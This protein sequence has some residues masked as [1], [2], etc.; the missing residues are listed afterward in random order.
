MNIVHN[1][2]IIGVKYIGQVNEAIP[3]FSINMLT[4]DMKLDNPFI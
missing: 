3:T 1:T 2:T 4:L